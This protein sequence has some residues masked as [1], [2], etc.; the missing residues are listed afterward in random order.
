MGR[1]RGELIPGPELDAI[2]RRGVPPIVALVGEEDFLKED[3]LRQVRRAMGDSAEVETFDG[4]RNDTEASAFDPARV[5]DGLRTGSL[6]GGQRIVAVRTADRFVKESAKSLGRL[7]EQPVRDAC[8]VVFLK[9]MDGRTKVA[10]LIAKVG[11][12][13][14]CGRL[15][16]RPPPWLIGKTP[17]HENDLAK[18]TQARAQRAGKRMSLPV[19]HGLAQQTGNDLG[20]IAGILESIAVY[21]GDRKE[22]DAEVVSE[23]AGGSGEQAIFRLCDEILERNPAKALRTLETT[24]RSGLGMGGKPV[25]DPQSITLITLGQLSKKI[26]NLYRA[27]RAFEGGEPPAQVMER[28]GPPTPAFQPVFVAQLSKFDSAALRRA[29]SSLRKIETALK[30][31]GDAEGP[32]LLF[33]TFVVALCAGRPPGRP[34]PAVSGGRGGGRGGGRKWG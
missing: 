5:F 25:R 17:E 1:T 15:Y 19:A 24:Y 23:L 6:F 20:R 9:R 13:V 16:D 30:S 31:G 32:A 12:K 29:I 11:M 21:L 34:F 33:E 27:R 10:R 2:L 4:P 7:L 28:Y 22:I 18:W 8:L 3:A 26:R 14:T